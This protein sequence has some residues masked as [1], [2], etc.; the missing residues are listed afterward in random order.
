MVKGLLIGAL[1][2]SLLF[3]GAT[4]TLAQSSAMSSSKPATKIPLPPS[5]PGPRDVGVAI[6][7]PGPE[8]LERQSEP[9]CEIP[10]SDRLLG[11]I[12]ETTRLIYERECYKNAE[13]VVRSK[14]QQLQD[15]IASTVKAL[16]DA[17]AIRTLQPAEGGEQG[18]PAPARDAAIAPEAAVSAKSSEA[19]GNAGDQR[20]AKS[21]LSGDQGVEPPDQHRKPTPSSRLPVNLSS[22]EGDVEKSSSPDAAVSELAH[23]EKTRGMQTPNMSAQSKPVMAST[24]AVACQASRPAGPGPRAWRLIDG[25]KCWYEGAVDMDKSLLHWPA[26]EISWPLGFLYPRSAANPS[27]GR[28]DR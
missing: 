16:N 20:E 27:S 5:P 12:S 25:R 2:I 9:D 11:A 22:P 3:T 1:S 18:A 10:S 26:P 23:H 6:P 15:A 7:L 13:T 19:P 14:L 4:V 17:G 28:P 21:D 24:K 8:L